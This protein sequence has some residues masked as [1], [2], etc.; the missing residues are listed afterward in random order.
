MNINHCWKSFVRCIKSIIGAG[1]TPPVYREPSIELTVILSASTIVHSMIVGD[2]EVLV[3]SD[4]IVIN[5]DE[6]PSHDHPL[7]IDPNCISVFT[8]LID[9]GIPGVSEASFLAISL[10]DVK[11]SIDNNNDVETN[12]TESSNSEMDW[13]AT[14]SL[15]STETTN[16]NH[17]LTI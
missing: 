11:Q 2:F 12:S 10:V 1:T 5:N 4:W 9:A 14:P 8:D 6:V 16:S 3:K 17:D 15:S 13:T 7:L